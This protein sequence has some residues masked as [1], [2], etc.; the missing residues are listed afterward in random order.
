MQRNYTNCVLQRNG[1]M[2]TV[3][4]FNVFEGFLAMYVVMNLYTK[5]SLYFV[6]SLRVF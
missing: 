1:I 2:R 3:A 4:L 5:C 6:E